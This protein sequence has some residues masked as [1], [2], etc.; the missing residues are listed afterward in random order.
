MSTPSARS[1]PFGSPRPASPT[2]PAASALLS[3]I[4]KAHPR[5]TKAWADTG[6]RTKAIDHGATLGIDIEIAHRDPDQKG[7]KVIPRRWVV[8]QTLGRLMN[9]RLAR[10]YETHPH[11]S[12]AMIRHVFIPVGAC[13]LNLQEGWW[14]IFR[15]TALAGQSFARPPEIDQ[16]TRL[17]T[18]QLNTRARPWISGRPAPPTRH[19]RRRHVYTV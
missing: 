5:A 7:F 3:N 14:R 6:Y 1:R 17:A 11:R 8:E 13:W 18:A 15:K 12:E 4:A 16:A 10:D 2:T 9:H 19:L